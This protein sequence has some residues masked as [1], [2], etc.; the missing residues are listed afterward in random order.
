M[1]D[2]ILRARQGEPDAVEE[3]LAAYEKRVYNL[4]LRLMLNAHDAQDMAQESLIK[5]F[6]SLPNLQTDCSFTSWVYRITVNTCLDELRRRKKRT[7]VNLD[8]LLQQQLPALQTS[9]NTVEDALLHRQKLE[10]IMGAIN[11]LDEEART[12]ILMRDVQGMAYQEIADTLDCRVGT[13]KSRIH[14]AR[15]KLMKVLADPEDLPYAPVR[16]DEG[17][18]M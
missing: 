16:A 8:D 9:Q 12:V 17:S 7:Y 14:R 4:S 5:V 13:V 2:L 18:A 15:K 6:R 10:Q 11:D 1:N 3:L